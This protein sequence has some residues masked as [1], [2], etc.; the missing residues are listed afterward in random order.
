MHSSTSSH[1]G[2]DSAIVLAL[3]GLVIGAAIG[4][5]LRPSVLLVGQ[6]PFETV[7][8]RGA[9]LSGLDQLLVGTAQTSFNVMAAGAAVG[10]IGGWF[11]GSVLGG[12]SRTDTRPS[13]PRAALASLATAVPDNGLSLC[14]ECRV[15]LEPRTD[16]C[17]EC[18]APAPLT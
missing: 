16:P 17:P 18:G 2:S 15:P 6:L 3:L 10:T 8:S 14:R 7:I 12:S 9:N 11:V 5:A 1:S 4:F 13:T